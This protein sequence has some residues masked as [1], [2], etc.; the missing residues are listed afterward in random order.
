MVNKIFSLFYIAFIFATSAL[1][2][3]ISVLI[4]LLTFPF[5]KRLLIL[6][7]YTCFWASVY[8]WLNPKWNVR[9]EGRE[10]F[11]WNKPYVIISNHQSLLDIIVVFRTFIHFKWVSKA[12]VFRLPFIGWNMVL[13]R[14]IKI[15]RGDKKSIVQMVEKCEKTLA[16]GSSVYFFPEGTRSFDGKLKHFKPGAFQLALKMKVPILPIIID[17][18]HEALRKKSLSFQTNRTIRVIILDEVPYESFQHMD[19]HQLTSHMFDYF[20]A[21]L[22]E[23]N[24][25]KL[26]PTED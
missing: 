24:L 11:N 15:K 25:N 5:D 6:H 3:P 26:R 23:R 18:T 13:N 12:E 2:L 10:K 16:E 14:Y 17:G 21:R 1:F 20:I 9:V 8:L 7:Q 19:T 4:K 22:E